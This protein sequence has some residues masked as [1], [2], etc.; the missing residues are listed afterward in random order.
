MIIP[1][2]KAKLIALKEDKEA[3]LLSLQRCGEFMA[4]PP[5]EETEQ[6][7]KNEQIDLDVQQADAM[8]RFMQRYQK[9]KSFFSDRPVYGYDEFIKRN[10]KGEALVQETSAISDKLSAAHSEIMTLKS[11][12]S[13]LEPWLSMDVPIEELRPTQYTNFHIGY[14]PPL[15]HEEIVAAVAEHN[16]EI[17]LFGK[18]AEGQAALIVS[19]MEDDAALSD[20]IKVLGFVEASLPRVTGTASEISKSNQEKN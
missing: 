12:C 19:F 15:V 16:A 14:L 8:L 11:E 7:A 3:L 4:I 20:N 18:T 5:D 17:Q 10:E 13:Q 1:M 2:K 6:T 9:K